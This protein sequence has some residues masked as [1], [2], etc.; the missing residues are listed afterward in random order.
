MAVPVSVEGLTE[1]IGVTGQPTKPDTEVLWQS[2]MT[3]VVKEDN[4]RGGRTDTMSWLV[5]V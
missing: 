5:V 4:G 2:D 3:G 1:Q